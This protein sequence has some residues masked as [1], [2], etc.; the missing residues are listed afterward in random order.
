MITLGNHKQKGER[1]A[2]PP[3]LKLAG[4]PSPEIMAGQSNMELLPDPQVSEG[5]LVGGIVAIEP[6]D[7]DT[8]AGHQIRLDRYTMAD[9]NVYEREFALPADPRSDTAIGDTTPW[10]VGREGF[11]RKV[12]GRFNEMG[13]PTI[14]VSP[15]GGALG[16][17]L[18]HSAHN[19]N[20]IIEHTLQDSDLR[21][22]VLGYGSS[23]AAAIALG[24]RGAEYI[25]V[26][27]PCFPR[28]LSASELPA[29]VLEA[30]HEVVEFGKHLLM[31]GPKA[32]SDQ[33]K[34][35]STNPTDWLHYAEVIPKLWN[36]D[37][38]RLS[39]GNSDTHTHITLLHKD[40]W[41][42]P[43]VWHAMAAE[44][45][46]LT[47]KMMNGRHLRIPDPKVLA[48]PFHRFDALAEMRG[49]DGDFTDEIL[50][51]VASLQPEPPDRTGRLGNLSVGRLVKAG[52]ALAA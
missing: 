46:K 16:A 18:R 23:R 5:F 14:G 17:S 39:W 35:F 50:A 42:K 32:A 49:A 47:I 30:G 7:S 3:S 12:N 27:A 6:I 41:S 19:M 36:G 43:D 45:P 26:I 8:Q 9:G 24:L 29:T 44:R 4:D 37:S 10:L 13:Y 51:E 52:L 15:V 34:T 1:M 31:I 33:R 11:N 28:P 21:P 22:S 40:G 25:D 38:G 48:G 2:G 20:D